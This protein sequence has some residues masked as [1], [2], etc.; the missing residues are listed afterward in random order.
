MSS[1]KIQPFQD[2]VIVERVP[3]EEKIG[4]LIIPTSAQEKTSEG[5]I[6]AVG[7][8]KELKDG[9]LRALQLSVGDKVLFDRYG[10]TEIKLDGKEYTLLRED[11]I[12][13]I[14]LE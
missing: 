2:R 4:S 6:R 5:F 9:T 8:G 13:G 14:V 1:F 3:S 10:G 12:Q 7:T 11:Q